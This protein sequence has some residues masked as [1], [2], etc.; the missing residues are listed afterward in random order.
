MH[1]SILV[2]FMP[3]SVELC[4]CPTYKLHAC[5]CVAF[6]HITSNTVQNQPMIGFVW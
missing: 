5:V 6:Q 2:F 4:N 3:H 1:K